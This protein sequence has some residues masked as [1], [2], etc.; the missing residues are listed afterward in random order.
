MGR[1]LIFFAALITASI[2]CGGCRS[3]SADNPSGCVN[4]L[5]MLAKSLLSRMNRPPRTGF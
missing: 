2:I 1:L 5:N 3:D 4:T